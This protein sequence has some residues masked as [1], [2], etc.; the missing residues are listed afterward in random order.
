MKK[1]SAI[2]LA[3]V[4]CLSILAVPAFAA[5][6]T[7]QSLAI[8]GTGIPGVGDWN[9]ADPAGDMTMVSAGIYE[10]TLELPAGT[11]M[12][13]KIAGNDTWDDTC[14]FGS[15]TIV[16]GEVAELT[17][18]GDSTDMSFTA[19]DAMTVK[20]TVDL[21]GDV[22]TILVAD[23]NGETTDKPVEEPDET[24]DEPAETPDEPT[25][26]P[27][28]GMVNIHAYVP[29]GT[30]PSFWAWEIS[31][32][33]NAFANWP[34]EPM[35][36]DGK[37]FTIQVPN[38]CDGMIVNNGSDS[39]TADLTVETGKEAWIVVQYDWSATVYYEEPNL[40]DV[41]Q[42]APPP[43]EKPAPS[44]PTLG[45]TQATTAAGKTDKT[46]APAADANTVTAYGMTFTKKAQALI[47]LGTALLAIVAIAFVLSIPKK[48]K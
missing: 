5:F 38:W 9:P 45:E 46:D 29:E 25:D 28:D 37:W 11:A 4:L 23:A 31:S 48:I 14:N 10:K 19:T 12:S 3:L 27:A 47:I 35:K 42:E 34:G 40:D 39:Q 13:F 17:C 44:R 16:L 33:K 41:I 7:V 1:I 22:A 24:P 6:D 15:A 18:A 26:A 8:V 36:A 32:Q 30:K 43:E 21:T 2:L 20:I